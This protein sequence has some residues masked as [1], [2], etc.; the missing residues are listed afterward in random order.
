MIRDQISNHIKITK[1]KV[2]KTLIYMCT[3]TPC[4]DL[5]SDLQSRESAQIFQEEVF[6]SMMSVWMRQPKPVKRALPSETKQTP[7]LSPVAGHG[8]AVGT[9]YDNCLQLQQPTQH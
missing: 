7:R 1:R 6:N 5:R 4:Q 2:C 8:H 3:K 9:L